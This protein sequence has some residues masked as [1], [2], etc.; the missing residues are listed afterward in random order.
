MAYIDWLKDR[1]LISSGAGY[2]L[3]ATTSRL[4][5]SKNDLN[6]GQGH[7]ASYF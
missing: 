6:V 5:T 7:S 1:S 2:V 4:V 3:V